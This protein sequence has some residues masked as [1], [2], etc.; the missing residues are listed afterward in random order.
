[1]KKIVPSKDLINEC[2]ALMKKNAV[3]PRK[4]MSTKQAR[5]LTENDPNGKIWKVGEEFYLLMSK[6]GSFGVVQ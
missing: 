6:H 5:R 2:I 4:V 3:K 1:M